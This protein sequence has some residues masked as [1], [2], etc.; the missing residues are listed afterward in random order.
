M[1]E[2]LRAEK[3]WLKETA[4]EIRNTRK[5]WKE[6][7]REFHFMAPPSTMNWEENMRQRAKMWA[8][9]RKLYKL[10]R[11]YRH[12]HIAYSLVRGNLYY[13]IE[14]T[15]RE[16]NKPDMTLVTKILKETYGYKWT[17]INKLAEPIEAE[18]TVCPKCY[19]IDC[20]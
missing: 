18:K 3:E 15:V 5:E 2:I 9:F 14:R 16:D 8:P 1:K 4:I 7:Q 17:D 13:E 6:N 20:K 19:R 11:E 12:R 10:S